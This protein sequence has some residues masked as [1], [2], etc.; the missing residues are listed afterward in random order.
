MRNLLQRSLFAVVAASVLLLSPSLCVHLDCVLAGEGAADLLRSAATHPHQSVHVEAFEAESDDGCASCCARS[1][2]FIAAG[3][4]LR[5]A[6][7]PS[8]SPLAVVDEVR[9]AVEPYGPAFPRG[10]PATPLV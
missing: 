2:R 8:S 7:T 10:P 5:F 6:P 4:A 9:F 1:L 3:G